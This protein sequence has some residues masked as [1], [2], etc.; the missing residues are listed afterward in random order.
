MFE[1]S[2]ELVAR[3]NTQ[4]GILIQPYYSLLSILGK[5]DQLFTKFPINAWAYT[6]NFT[7]HVHCVSGGPVISP[8]NC[9]ECFARML[10]EKDDEK[11]HFQSGKLYVQKVR[12][13][14]S[15]LSLCCVQQ[16]RYHFRGSSIKCLFENFLPSLLSQPLGSA[17]SVRNL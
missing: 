3:L 9:D 10:V 12:A 7:I 17:R 15:S 16:L 2:R 13:L 5:G 8:M 11:Y 4:L 1:F 6:R 14:K